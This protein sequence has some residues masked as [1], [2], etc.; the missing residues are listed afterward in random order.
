L[1]VT[2]TDA[3]TDA[4]GI[5]RWKSNNRV[6][7]ADC[8]RELAPA[9]YDHAAHASARDAETGAFLADYR[10]NP[11]ALTPEDVREMRAAGLTG[12]VENVITGRRH[13]LG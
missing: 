11:P 1:G 9:G 13:D 6:L 4:A 2:L 8:A 7:P 5:L 3:Y 10:A 12:I